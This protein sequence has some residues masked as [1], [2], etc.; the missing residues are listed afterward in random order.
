MAKIEVPISAV[1]TAERSTTFSSVKRKDLDRIITLSSNVLEG[2]NAN[3]IVAQM[4]TALDGFEVP[5][6]VRFAF[7]GQQEEQAKELAFFRAPS[8][9]RCF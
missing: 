3:E 8:C 9:L 6:G 5:N 2:A 4:E 7:T 1:A